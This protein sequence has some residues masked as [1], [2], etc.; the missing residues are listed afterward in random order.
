M[1]RFHKGLVVFAIAAVL[2][3][4]MAA[5]GGSGAPA[6]GDGDAAAG[7]EPFANTSGAAVHISDASS[8]GTV[9]VTLTDGE[10]LVIM[11]NFESN[12]GEGTANTYMNGENVGTD[13]FYEGYSYSETGYEPGDYTVE[14]SA[15]G[16][17][18]TVWVLAYPANQIDVMSMETQEIVE[19][20]LADVA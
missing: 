1:K 20:V 4:A 11:A 12:P 5:C 13:Y 18:G 19:K 15:P 16:A 7:V 9:D 8:E 6:S 17:T 10:A 2:S 3:L 14:V